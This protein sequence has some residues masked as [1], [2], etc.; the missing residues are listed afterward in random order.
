MGLSYF[1]ELNQ[2]RPLQYEWIQL[3]QTLIVWKI[4]FSKKICKRTTKMEILQ[5]FFLE[6]VKHKFYCVVVL[7]KEEDC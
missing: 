1:W 4:W 7:K 3:Q 6:E 5:F 2:Q